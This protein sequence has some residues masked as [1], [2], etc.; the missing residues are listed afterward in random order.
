MTVTPHRLDNMHAAGPG[1]YAM[2]GA[3]SG[4]QQ[5]RLAQAAL[6]EYPEPPSRSNHSAAHGP[7]PRLWEAAQLDLRLAH[8]GDD[9]P[10]CCSE[11]QG[12]ARQPSGDHTCSSGSSPRQREDPGGCCHSCGGRGPCDSGVWSRE[13]PGPSARHLLSTLRW[14][15]LGPQY[16]WTARAYDRLSP[17]TPL[18]P[19]LAALAQR[20]AAAAA[21]LDAASAACA[22]EE[23]ACTAKGHAPSPVGSSVRL[24][25]QSQ[26]CTSSMQTASAEGCSHALEADSLGAVGAALEQHLAPVAQH[27]WRA[28]DR[29]SCGVSTPLNSHQ[30]RVWEPDVALVNLYREGDTLGGHQDDVERDKEAPIVAISLGCDA[31]FLLGGESAAHIGA[32]LRICSLLFFTDCSGC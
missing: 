17:H 31:I 13:G 2:P 27:C 24:P 4:E 3:L 5:Q 7:L 20:F 25:E 22:H 23:Q 16:C 29:A 14:V 11:P 28:Q 30:S 21:E 1:F 18:P 8:A 15:T 6:Q 32:H 10:R 26:I 19:Q 9:S 12:C